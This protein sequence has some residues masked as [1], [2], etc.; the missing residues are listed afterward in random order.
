[1]NE[2]YHN[3]LRSE[4]K[5]IYSGS[6]TLLL[7]SFILKIDKLSTQHQET[8]GVDEQFC[9]PISR[10][11]PWNSETEIIIHIVPLKCLKLKCDKVNK[12]DKTA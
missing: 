8:I 10:L 3:F 12:E 11:L 7:G 1:M 9:Y 4:T 6:I 2:A 5:I